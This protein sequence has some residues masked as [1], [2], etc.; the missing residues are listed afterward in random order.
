MVS[1]QTDNVFENNVEESMT[2]QNAIKKEE[3]ED[4]YI[5]KTTNINC[6]IKDEKVAR[7]ATKFA[8]VRAKIYAYR[9]QKYDHE[10][11]HSDIIKAKR[12]KTSASKELTFHDF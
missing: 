12:V 11:K 9:I 5:Q 2:H 7:I 3:N 1:I 4:H 6:L 10:T 8:A